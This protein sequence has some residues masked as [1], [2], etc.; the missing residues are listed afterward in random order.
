[1]ISKM[2]RNKRNKYRSRLKSAATECLAS[3]VEGLCDDVMA[4][5]TLMLLNWYGLVDQMK[6]CY[7]CYERG[8]DLNPEMCLNEGISYYFLLKHLSNYDSKTNCIAPALACLPDT[9]LKFFECRT[10]Y[11]EIV[12]DQRLEG[13]YYLLPPEC[14]TGKGYAISG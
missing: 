5:Q 1:M 13:V 2:C 11:V 10:G 3:L 6:T 14:V 4:M 8:T 9:I 7:Q 12:R